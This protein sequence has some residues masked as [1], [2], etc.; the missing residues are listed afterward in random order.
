MGNCSKLKQKPSQFGESR[1]NRVRESRRKHRESS[2]NLLLNST[3]FPDLSANTEDR[4]VLFSFEHEI[5][6]DLSEAKRRDSDA[7]HG[8]A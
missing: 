4:E 8:M 3:V 6:G 2:V 1:R 5:A 7:W